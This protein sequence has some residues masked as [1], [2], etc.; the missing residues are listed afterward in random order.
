MSV[1]AVDVSTD[2]NS[3]ALVR[4]INELTYA[5]LVLVL[6]LVLVLILVGDSLGVSVGVGDNTEEVVVSAG[7]TAVE[8]I[9]SPGEFLMLLGPLEVLILLI[10]TLA[11][12]A[13]LV[14]VLVSVFFISLVSGLVVDLTL[15]R[16]MAPL[17]PIIL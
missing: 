10:L 5:A 1:P 2:D 14:L 12:A 13:V 6:V 15:R 7:D 3:S 16:G 17:L 9:E 8:E 11:V 4:S